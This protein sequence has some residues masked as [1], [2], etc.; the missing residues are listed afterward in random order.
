MPLW[1]G[2]RGVDGNFGGSGLQ[3]LDQQQVG[4]DVAFAVARPIA[5]KIGV[6]VSHIQGLIGVSARNGKN[7]TLSACHVGATVS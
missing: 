1:Q 4:L 7:R 6:A 5:G 2:V 3:P